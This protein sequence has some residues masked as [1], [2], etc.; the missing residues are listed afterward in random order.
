MSW[1]FNIA[2]E[3]IANSPMEKAVD[4]KSSIIQL[5]SGDLWEIFTWK[6]DI[7]RC[8]WSIYMHVYIYI[9]I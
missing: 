1:L 9:Y 7:P 3:L 4:N 8:Y 6:V 2:K 5:T